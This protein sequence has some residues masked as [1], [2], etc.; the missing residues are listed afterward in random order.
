MTQDKKKQIAAKAALQYVEENTIVAVGT[1]STVHYFIEA[2]STIKHK[3]QGAIA[4]SKATEAKLKAYG[5]PVFDLNGVQEVPVYIDG[6]DAY[7]SYFQLIKGGGGALTRE[8]ILAAAS[9]K[10]I[11]ST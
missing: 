3:I 6:A 7:N 2:L 9:Q 1:G 5:I 8:K 4:S 10:F 11:P